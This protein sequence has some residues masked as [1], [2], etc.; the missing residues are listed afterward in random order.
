[1]ARC[2]SQFPPRLLRRA[3]KGRMADRRCQPR[4]AAGASLRGGLSMKEV[5]ATDVD[6]R[7]ETERM[8]SDEAAQDFEE[9]YRSH[10][11]SMVRL[12][13]VVTGSNAAAEDLVQDAFVKLAPRLESR[14]DPVPYLRAMVLNECRMWFRRRDVEARHSTIDDRV[15]LPPELDTTWV[16]LLQLPPR[17]RAA[18]YLRYY[19]DLSVNDIAEAMGCRPSTVRSLL[20]RGLASMKEVVDHG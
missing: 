13:H 12:A 14:R 2:G 3:S 1:M 11:I 16:H 20:R 19:E 10:M 7:D 15:V 17:R 8:D 6:G 9:F 5:M 4:S 18:L